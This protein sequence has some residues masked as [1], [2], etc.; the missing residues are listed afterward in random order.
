MLPSPSA[1]MNVGGMVHAGLRDLYKPSSHNISYWEK[2]REERNVSDEVLFEADRLVQGYKNRYFSDGQDGEWEVISAELPISF[3]VFNSSIP[4]TYS[5][6]ADL[7]V[8]HK[9]D[10]LLWVPD[11]KTSNALSSSTILHYVYSPQLQGYVAAIQAGLKEKVEGAC[12]NL[13]VK[14]K[15]VQFHR[16][17]TPINEVW[18]KQWREAMQTMVAE[19]VESV[20]NHYLNGRRWESGYNLDRTF[21]QNRYEC[22][23]YF[24]SDCPFRL[25]CWHADSKLTNSIRSAYKENK[26]RITYEQA[27]EVAKKWWGG[28]P[29]EEVKDENSS[30]STS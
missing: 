2:E 30:N 17:Y 28:D 18:M 3:P 11:H 8:R 25:A 21:P 29:E 9:R 16:E 10:G 19:L 4:V 20:C 7:L 13:I 22:V 15:Q 27:E 6:T 1:Q 24:G 5:G 14:T 26:A 23:P 12:V